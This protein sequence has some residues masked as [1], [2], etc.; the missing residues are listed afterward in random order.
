MQTQI[1]IFLII[2]IIRNLSYIVKN[3]LK[4]KFAFKLKKKIL[5]N[6]NAGPNV[7]VVE[8]ISPSSTFKDSYNEELLS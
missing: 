1:N 3:N 4:K 8:I 6:G 7:T 2:W 5:F